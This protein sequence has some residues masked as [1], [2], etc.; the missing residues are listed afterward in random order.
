MQYRNECS[1]GRASLVDLKEGRGQ[2]KQTFRHYR[3]ASPGPAAGLATHSAAQRPEGLERCAGGE[4]LG[5]GG[6]DGRL[7]GGGRPL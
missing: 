2:A 3:G 7:G 5:A 4:D 1:V 6:G